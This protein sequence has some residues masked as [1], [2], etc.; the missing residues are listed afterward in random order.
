MNLKKVLALLAFAS[1]S[2][3]QVHADPITI[4][5][6]PTA[7]GSSVEADLE[8][9][10]FDCK[11]KVTLAE[12]L[13]DEFFSLAE[14]ESIEIDFFDIQ[15]WAR[16][17]IG[18]VSIKAILALVTPDAILGGS[19]DGAFGSIFGRF[20]AGALHW[21]NQPKAVDL[22]DGTFLQVTFQDL[23]GVTKSGEKNTVHATFHRFS[24][25]VGVPEPAM[26]GLLGMGLILM[27]FYGRRNR[28]VVRR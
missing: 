11:V 9:H 8:C 6:D 16:F 28:S 14:G 7:D 27:A 5:I 20:V 10:G 12:T 21:E 24:A 2:I 1:L 22:G 18:E 13:E 15:V 26:V 19:G 3:G 4:D 17:A 25:P 23:V